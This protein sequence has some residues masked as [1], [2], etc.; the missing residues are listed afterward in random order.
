MKI[1]ILLTPAK[2]ADT[3]FSSSK[4]FDLEVPDGITISLEC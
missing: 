4:S 3:F 2:D 1:R